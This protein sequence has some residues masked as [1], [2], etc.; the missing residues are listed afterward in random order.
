MIRSLV[1][2]L[3]SLSLISC[4]EDVPSHKLTGT[5]VDAHSKEPIASASVSLLEDGPTVVT[6]EDGTFQFDDASVNDIK[7]IDLAGSEYCALAI[8]HPDFY[9]AEVN[10]GI[11][12]NTALTLSPRSIPAY[13]YHQP[14]QLNDGLTTSTLSEAGFDGQLI[15]N[16]MDKVVRGDFNE[17]H[18]ILIY[19]DGM[20][21]LE[22]YFFGN[23]DTIK[24]EENVTVDRNPEHIQWTRKTPHYVASVNK[25]LTSTILGIALDESGLD[26]NDKIS[27]NLPQYSTYF[28]AE[29]TAALDFEDCLTMTAGFKWDEWASNDLSLLWKSDDFGAF[30]LSRENMGAG[31]EWKYNSALPNL[32][33]KAVDNMVGGNVR[34][35]AHDN[36]YAKLGIEN[37]KWQS[38]PDGYP[39]GSARMYLTPRDMLKIGITYLHD[40][41]W[42]GEQVIPQSWVNACK[43]VKVETSSG[44]YSYHFWIRQLNGVTYLSADGDGGNYINIFPDQN[45][46][47]VF[48]QGLYLQWPNYVV[49]ADKMMGDFIIPAIE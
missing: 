9:P 39:E 34:A 29:S 43:E 1:I 40:G 19:K 21:A 20:L 38:Q 24:F 22:E 17:V 27:T 28:D 49:Q 15:H 47:I 36:F 16:M 41:Q 31:S 45:M 48:T 30:V 11:G 32:M 6:N 8:S 13:F 18:S 42:A 35:W 3:L 44:D 14:V 46:V 7:L 37:Y 5:I 4:K 12:T 26:V 33:L 10:I 23:N 25:A 2:S